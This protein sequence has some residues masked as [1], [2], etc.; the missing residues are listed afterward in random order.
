MLYASDE[1][2]LIISEAK[3]RKLQELVNPYYKEHYSRTY[4]LAIVQSLKQSQV[5]VWLM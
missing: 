4:K 2:S 5:S 3:S 1:N